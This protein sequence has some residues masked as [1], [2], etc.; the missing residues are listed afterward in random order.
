MTNE[1]LERMDEYIINEVG[2]YNTRLNKI[3]HLVMTNNFYLYWAVLM[4]ISTV[5]DF[6]LTKQILYNDKQMFLSLEQNQLLLWS[7]KNNMWYVYALVNSILI[8]IIAFLVIY[9]EKHKKKDLIFVRY[10]MLSIPLSQLTQP[11]YGI[12]VLRLY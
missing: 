1:I 6:A 9:I 10:F 4:I 3:K 11:L 8:I 5:F 7:L 2:K 12:L